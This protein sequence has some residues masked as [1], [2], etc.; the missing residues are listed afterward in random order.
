MVKVNFHIK[1]HGL[2]LIKNELEK[3]IIGNANCVF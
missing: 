1:E 3:E 2:Y